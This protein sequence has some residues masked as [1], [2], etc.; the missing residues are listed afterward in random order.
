MKK[1]IEIR[2]R[3]EG[4]YTLLNKFATDGS[5]PLMDMA[6]PNHDGEQDAEVVSEMM[7]LRDR[8][9]G[10]KHACEMSMDALTSAIG[11]D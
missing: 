10:L 5:L 7:L 6:Y 8:L 4:F 9:N 1:I 3:A 2:E 11:D